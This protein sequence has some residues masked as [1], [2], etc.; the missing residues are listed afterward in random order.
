MFTLKGT[1]EIGRRG[2]LTT[3]H[4]TIETPF[5]MPVG[6]AGAMKGITHDDLLT[7][8]AQVLLCNTYHLHLQP[9]E[10]TVERAGGLHAFI[11]WEK[12]ILTD[13][14]GYQVFSFGK[15]GR[16]GVTEE[17]VQF[18]S[19]LNGDTL[20]IGPKESMEIQHKL[21][22]DI[23]MVFDECP[24][25]TA[26]RKEI[27]S[28]VDR[29]L[30]WAKE[31]KRFH[32]K[33]KNERKSSPSSISS[34]PP[35]LFGIVQGGLER[36]LREKCAQ[37]LQAIGFDGYAI[38]GLA[39]GESEADMLSVVEAVCPLLPEGAPR[40]LMGVGEIEQLRS[41]V[42]RGIDMFD[43]VLPMR[44]ARHGMVLLS[45]GT[46]L[47]ITNSEFKESHIPI[48]PASPVPGSRTH[49]RSY[50]HHLLRANERLGETI[51]QMQ[52]LGVT[53]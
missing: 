39:V 9:G 24:P 30:R 36:D 28:A 12:P 20:F 53:L 19:H 34:F 33:Y 46:R 6:T 26:K 2:R 38:G 44:I 10:E 16:A 21:G 15:N 8:G 45:D 31:C 22:S 7:L 42:A 18:Q 37:E 23:I 5:F 32:E 40:Y 13:S 25:S 17:G 43:C 49:L 35:L 50:L 4:G 48:D 1:N 14:G 11:G 51:A 27:Q 41:C 29:T 3:A 52:N 47:K